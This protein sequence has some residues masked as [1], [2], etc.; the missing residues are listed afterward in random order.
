MK[1]FIEKNII[2]FKNDKISEITDPI[3]NE[4]TISLVI[5]YKQ[6]TSI[7]CTPE[8][9]KDL[10]AGFLF[11]SGITSEDN[12]LLDLKYDEKNNVVHIKMENNDIIKEL[13]FSKM[14][15]VGCGSGELLFAKRN[16]QRLEN[17]LKIKSLTISSLMKEFNKGSELFLKT[18]GVH[19]AALADTEKM[20]VFREDIGRHNAVDK[21]I[22]NMY[23]NDI[24]LTDK[25][26]LTS[27]RISSEIVMKVINC[28]I[29]MIISRSAPTIKA[30]ELAEKNNITLIGFARSTNFNVYTGSQNINFI[31]E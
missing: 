22:G 9:L 8:H 30:V 1:S 24:S 5:N 3:V 2:K 17:D 13:I 25:V 10:A 12:K 31:Q 19:S 6:L 27:G 4:S 11:T 28:K 26:I 20:L 18:G 23:L 21:V 16:I 14:R 29:P 7:A 15:P